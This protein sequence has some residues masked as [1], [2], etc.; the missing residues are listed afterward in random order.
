MVTSLSVAAET[1]ATAMVTPAEGPSF[2][3]APAGTCMCTSFF[4]KKSS[5]MP[6]L[7]ALARA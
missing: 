6:S 5:S 2:G 1:R 3:I 7:S 4:S